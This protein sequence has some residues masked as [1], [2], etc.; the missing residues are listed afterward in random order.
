MQ[1]QLTDRKYLIALHRTDML[2]AMHT[3]QLMRRTTMGQG[4]ACR[5]RPSGPQHACGGCCESH[6]STHV[7]VIETPWWRHISTR[8]W[9]PLRPSQLK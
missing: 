2:F 5:R 9:Y 6:I 8:L 4:R 7:S 1:R 3:T